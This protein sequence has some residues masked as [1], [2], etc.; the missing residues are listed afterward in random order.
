MIRILLKSL[1]IYFIFTS[2]LFSQ[3]INQI[4]INGN[5]RISKESVIIFSKLE[6]GSNYNE[7]SAN[8]S[9]KNLYETNFFK[10]VN[11]TFDKNKL[12]INLIENPIIE[13][14]EL[15][16]IKKKKFFIFYKRKNVFKRKSF[17]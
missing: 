1:T 12:T 10:D 3:T 11:I 17:L 9:I 14:L 2:V 4:V 8:E 5:K 6:I 13:E 15:T 16:G 7:N